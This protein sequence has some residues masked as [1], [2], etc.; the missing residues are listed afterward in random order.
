MRSHAVA[1]ARGAPPRVR[2]PPT[3]SQQPRQD[4]AVWRPNYPLI[5]G[6]V[7]LAAIAVVVAILVS[8]GGHPTV[9]VIQVQDAVPSTSTTPTSTPTTTAPTIA[10]SAVQEVLGRYETAYSSENLEGLKGLFASSL[11]RQNGTQPSEGLKQALA[12]YQHQFAEQT[13]PSYK[14]SSVSIQPGAG[15]ATA[16]AHYGITNQNGTLTGSI[17]FHLTEENGQLLI[18]KLTIEPSK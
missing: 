13:N 3:A 1:E 10:S 17:V 9:P 15:E 18:D 4:R 7:V 11:A 12:T 8:S 14:L 6:I 16:S 2:E 5:G